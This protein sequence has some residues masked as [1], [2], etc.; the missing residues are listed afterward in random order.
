MNRGTRIGPMA[1]VPPL[2]LV[3]APTLEG[4]D[5]AERDRDLSVGAYGF[6]DLALEK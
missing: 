3:T 1:Y 6:T 2:T 4:V 5:G